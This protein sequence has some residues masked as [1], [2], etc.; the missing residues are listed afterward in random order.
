MIYIF[1]LRRQ[2]LYVVG[3]QSERVRTYLSSVV[4]TLFVKYCDGWRTHTRSW[5]V[6]MSEKQ[7]SPLRLRDQLGLSSSLE[8]PVDLS[9]RL[10]GQWISLADLC[11][12]SKITYDLCLFKS[13]AE[14]WTSSLPHV[15]ADYRNSHTSVFFSSNLL[16]LS[17]NKTICH[18]I[19][20]Q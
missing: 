19:H 5:Q 16:I 4:G 2:R 18:S 12:Q 1:I 9:L 17:A 20:R 11:L 13:H 3:K 8:R 14:V 7:V 6:C 15:L 10:C